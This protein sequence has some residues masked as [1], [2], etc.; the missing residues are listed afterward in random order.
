MDGVALAS[1]GEEWEQEIGEPGERSRASPGAGAALPCDGAG[2]KESAAW[3]GVLTLDFGAHGAEEPECLSRGEGD[4][5]RGSLRPAPRRATAA[6][7]E[8]AQAVHRTH[9]LC[10][11]SRA[12]ALDRATTSPL[13]QVPSH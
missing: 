9:L 3:D 4:G 10:L 5:R 13:L 2:A 11:L 12:L 6:D 8:L 1:E 7:K